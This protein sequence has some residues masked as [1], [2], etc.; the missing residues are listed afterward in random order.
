MRKRIALVV[1]TLSGGGAEKVVSNLSRSLAGQYDIDIIVNDMRHLDYPY[2]G[3]II[4]LKMPEDRGT[5][6]F[7]IQVVARRIRVLRYLKKR[8]DYAA[9]ISF[10]GMCNVSNV[11]SGTQFA[12]TILTVHNSL[13]GERDT[14]WVHKILSH[15]LMPWCYRKADLTVSVSKGIKDELEKNRGLPPERSKVI[16][17][18][19][20]TAL[21]W[22]KARECP[23]EFE[24]E[25]KDGKKLIVSV[26][27][28]TR[29]K[30]HRYLLKAVKILKSEGVPIHLV[31]LGEGELR[32][33]LENQA[34]Q[35][36]ISE[37]LTFA[38]F[39]ENPY[40]YMAHADAVV[41]PS[42]YVQTS[43]TFLHC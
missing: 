35:L 34:A 29:Q 30:G 26:G 41:M 43:S 27:R 5:M 20:E 23:A 24:K 11:L 15:T 1:N 10:S 19:T 7:Q 25:K 22:K 8:R 18:G 6:L 9:V 40:K 4:S 21:I 38:G 2:R 36:G 12:K 33:E 32:E 17:N 14:S 28:L 16:Y 42:L 3:H 37:D 39:V 31:L 13:T